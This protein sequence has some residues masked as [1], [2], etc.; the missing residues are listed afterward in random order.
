MAR[1]KT[2]KKGRKKAKSAKAGSKAQFR[3]VPLPVG[4]IRRY[5][6]GKPIVKGEHY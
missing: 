1:H 4:T 6:S 5:K 3:M 2:R